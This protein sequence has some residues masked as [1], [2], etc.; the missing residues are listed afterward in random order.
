MIANRM[1]LALA[2]ASVF[3]ACPALRADIPD[4]PESIAF[5]ELKF[6]PPKSADFRHELSTG[7][8]VYLAPSR[9]FP[10]INVVFTFRGGAYLDPAEKV[11]LAEA[12]GSMIRRG[13]TTTVSPSD[14]D[15]KFDF[16]AANAGANSGDI[17]SSA[18]LNCLASNFDES[19]ALFID[20]LRHPGFDASRLEIYAHEVIEDLRQRNDDA[21]PILS[22]EWAA[23]MYGRDHFEARQPTAASI[24]S[25]TP[26]DLR[27]MHQRIFNPANLVIAVSGD[28]D[29]Q[30]MLASLEQAL[31]GWE[32]GEKLGEPPAPDAAFAPGLYHVEKDI[33]QGKVNIGVRGIKR[34]DPDYFPMLILNDILGGGGFTS[35]I[36]KRVRSDEGLAYSAGS[37][38]QTEV[39]YPGQ[40]RASFQSKNRTVALATKIILEEINRVRTDPVSE[41]ELDVAKNGFIETLPRTFESK[42]GMLNVFVNDELTGRS[43]EYWQTYRDQVRS[44]SAADIQRVAKEHLDPSKLAIFVVGNWDEIYAGDLEGRATMG[45]FF[46]GNVN[47]LPLRDPLTL[48]P[49]P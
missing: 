17:F 23:L 2:A 20:M 47:H 40:W 18:S 39:Y 49:M 44:V 31:S 22:R 14:L 27:A 12:T 29:P 15:E 4:R 33:P 30:K 9:E 26:E 21:T 7:V 13:G 41:E 11:G 24:S 48:E 16:L 43:P 10:L 46:S 38:M 3:L 36:T 8:P 19:F 32:F 45:E 6:T 28:F 37:A 5:P 42:A 34:D 1:I 25:I 35:R